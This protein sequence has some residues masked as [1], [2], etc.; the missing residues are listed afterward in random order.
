MTTIAIGTRVAGRT[1]HGDTYYGRVER[2]LLGLVRLDVGHGRK[3]KWVRRSSVWPLNPE[4]TPMLVATG[5]PQWG[6]HLEGRRFAAIDPN[7]ELPSDHARMEAAREHLDFET[8]SSAPLAFPDRPACPT[9]DAVFDDREL[10][11]GLTAQPI[12]HDGGAALNRRTARAL[13]PW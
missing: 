10:V 8:R 4:P 11:P 3:P 5:D 13:S 6:R 9:R 12:P 1:Q 7:E 2:R